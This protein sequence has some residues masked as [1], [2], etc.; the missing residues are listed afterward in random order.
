MAD[1]TNQSNRPP[2][3]GITDILAQQGTFSALEGHT[4]SRIY[5]QQ[6]EHI[7]SKIGEAS[8]KLSEIKNMPNSAVRANVEAALKKEIDNLTYRSESY[9]HS[10]MTSTINAGVN[11]IGRDFS[12][13][14]MMTMAQAAAQSQQARALSYKLFN[15]TP[16]ELN[17]MQAATSHQMGAIT[18]D[19]QTGYAT[20][21]EVNKNAR[22]GEGFL[23]M[24]PEFQDIYNTGVRGM[25]AAISEQAGIIAAQRSSARFDSLRARGRALG[26]QQEAAA[27]AGLFG[28]G[29]VTIGG[30]QIS[31]KNLQSEHDKTVKEL[32]DALKEL[33]NGVKKSAEEE[34]QLTE[35]ISKLDQ[36]EQDLKEAQSATGGGGGVGGS[37]RMARAASLLQVAGEVVQFGVQQRAQGMA[38]RSAIGGLANQRYD[39]YTAAMG[40]DMASLMALKQWEAAKDFGAQQKIGTGVGNALLGLGMIAGGVGAAVGTGGIGA[41]AGGAAVLAGGMRLYDTFAG[42]SAT[43]AGIGGAQQG[44]AVNA[45]MNYVNA[46]QVQGLRDYGVGMGMVNASLGGGGAFMSSMLSSGT[47]ARM[48]D[49]SISPQQMVQMAQ[50]GAENMGS[51]FNADQI[52]A[53][54]GLEKSGMGTMA[55]NI[56]RMGMLAAA[57][58]NN[59]QAGLAQILEAAVGKGFDSS[60]SMDILVQNTAK[61][62]SQ[63]RLAAMS[64]ISTAGTAAAMIASTKD[65]SLENK[66]FATEVAADALQTV[67]NEA[68]NVDTSFGGRVNVATMSRLTGLSNLG[69]TFAN[70]I[71]PQ[72]LHA[73]RKMVAEGKAEEVKKILVNQGVPYGELTKGVTVEGITSMIDAQTQNAL[74]GGAG[75]ALLS[76]ETQRKM[77]ENAKKPNSVALTYEE[78]VAIGQAAVTMGTT[79]NTFTSA[80]GAIATG[81]T[82]SSYAH[83][84]VEAQ[85]KGAGGSAE[86]QTAD[87]LRTMGDKQQAEAMI[88]AARAMGGAKDALVKIATTMET[89]MKDTP[90]SGAA[91]AAGEEIR[92]LDII[93]T[94][95]DS[96]WNKLDAVLTKHYSKSGYGP[97][98]TSSMSDNTVKGGAGV[99]Q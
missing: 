61:M 22:Q 27:S 25:G 9:V 39:A 12:T 81:G 77:R 43:A 84:Q 29:T 75:M 66:E 3:N 74:R 91:K 5:P 68:T 2:P 55:N 46:K 78:E 96:S 49:L 56:S 42:T 99:K 34:A 98:S 33:N 59:P 20:S 40:G 8:S 45:Q 41:A 37:G 38:N 88:E 32:I 79:G 30:E 65:N 24:N 83:D 73:M 47:M 4:T 76:S 13:S 48:S 64:G 94:K 80:L 36:K 6:Q 31:T 67:T 90:E 16:Y 58:S 1:D 17:M 54:R 97:L 52:F 71:S 18:S 70:K 7:L 85:M 82:N 63:D 26:Y 72:Q 60:K 57:G 11:R 19:I 28:S 87:K 69:A 53:A 14:R 21:V 95:F 92:G 35:A 51:M 44:L 10:T 93:V 50:M 62:A 89:I 15:K 86:Q 23:A